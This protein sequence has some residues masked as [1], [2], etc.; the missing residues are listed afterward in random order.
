MIDGAS[1]WSSFGTWSCRHSPRSSYLV[2]TIRIMDLFRLF[3]AIYILTGGR[4]GTAAETMTF[5]PI[6][7]RSSF[8]R[9]GRGLR[10]A[11]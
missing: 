5:Y 6:E 2:L 1:G 9:S 10:S 7:W 3:D 8:S 4:T 11:S